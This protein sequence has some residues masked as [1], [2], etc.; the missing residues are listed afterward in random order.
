M[1][2]PE[3]IPWVGWPDGYP[4][5]TAM[6]PGLR[7]DLLARPPAS[8]SAAVCPSKFPLASFCHLPLCLSCPHVPN[9]PAFLPS[10]TSSSRPPAPRPV[11]RCC[12]R[13]V[14]SC[15]VPLGLTPSIAVVRDKRDNKSEKKKRGER[16]N[17]NKRFQNF[18]VHALKMCKQTRKFLNISFFAKSTA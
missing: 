12:P 6:L 2:G 15:S 18:F 9:Q 10:P 3:F 17:S 13:V 5:T 16:E 1:R 4:R 8:Y 14:P 11:P 7:S